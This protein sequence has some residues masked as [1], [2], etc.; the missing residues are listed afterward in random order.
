VLTQVLVTAGVLTGL[1]ALARLFARRLALLRALGAPG[2]FVFAVVWS[3]AATLIVL[4]AAAGLGA[5]WIAVDVISSIVTSRTDILVTA[6]LD[7][8]EFHLIAG[9][10]S[11][12]VLLALLPAFMAMSRN[13]ITDLRA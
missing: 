8:P 3:Y 13:I 11:L 6:T 10:V 4:G 2:R 7:W 9:F 5:G 1:I 12:T